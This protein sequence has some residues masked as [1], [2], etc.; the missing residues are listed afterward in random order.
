MGHYEFKPPMYEKSIE[1]QKIVDV[2]I[3]CSKIDSYIYTKI[4]SLM[5]WMHAL[6]IQIIKS[7]IKHLN[8]IW[9]SLSLSN[10][11]DVERFVIHSMYLSNFIK[12]TK[13]KAQWL[14][15]NIESALQGPPICKHLETRKQTLTKMQTATFCLIVASYKIIYFSW[16]VFLDLVPSSVIFWDLFDFVNTPEI[17]L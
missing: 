8:N 15:H 14:C 10:E 3:P 4:F 13:K 7:W 17:I 16:I 1:K 6:H 2:L 11:K 12:Q 9:Y 5:W